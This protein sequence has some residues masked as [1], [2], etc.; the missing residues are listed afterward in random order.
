MK[1]DGGRT[2]TTL[3]L[4]SLLFASLIVDY[5]LTLYFSDG[6]L[7]NGELSPILRYAA[8]NGFATQWVIISSI[9]ITFI[10]F[11]S[12]L[13]LQRYD[14]AYTGAVVI[15]LLLSVSHILAG[16]S[17]YLKNT[18]YSSFIFTLSLGLI[19][20]SIFIFLALMIKSHG[21]ALMA[22]ATTAV[23]LGI[24]AG[25]VILPGLTDNGPRP[26]ELALLAT[27]EVDFTV[28]KAGDSHWS[29]WNDE[30]ESKTVYLIMETE[31]LTTLWLKLQWEDDTSRGDEFAGEKDTLSLNV[32]APDGQVWSG[33]SS[34]GSVE[35]LIPVNEVPSGFTITAPTPPD[36]SPFRTSNGTG[37][38]RLVVTVED[39][40]GNSEYVD[41]DDGNSWDLYASWVSYKAVLK[42][43]TT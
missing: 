9:A 31:N 29:D 8:E 18:M 19:S 35:I 40:P 39:S 13:Y 28:E 23:V 6:D 22:S 4:S 3:A 20:S 34:N 10:I 12:L 7:L 16:L 41:L 30:G 11:G 25:A 1:D 43:P 32:E 33:S 5:A 14:F 26:V 38:W 27:W 24:L 42:G 36:L 15:I 37:T 21:Q 17:W 2:W